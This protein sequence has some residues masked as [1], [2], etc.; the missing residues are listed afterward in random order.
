MRF[1]LVDR[2]WYKLVESFNPETGNKHTAK[3]E[4]SIVDV[5]VSVLLDTW[6]ELVL[7]LDATSK[8]LT[9]LKEQ[10]NQEKFK[11]VFMSDINFKELYNSTAEK[12]REQHAKKELKDLDDKITGFELYVDWVKQ[13]IPLLKEVIHAKQYAK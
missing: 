10:Y 4:C 13:Y 1:E 5:P 12:V 9:E 3:I 6:E 11:I 2:K 7:D 8:T